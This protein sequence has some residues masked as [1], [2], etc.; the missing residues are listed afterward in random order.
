MVKRNAK[1]LATLRTFLQAIDGAPAERQRYVASP[2]DFTRHRSLT[3]LCMVGLLA[4]LL[5]RSLS[6]ELREFFSEALARPHGV[7]KSAFCQQRTK[8]KPAL[9]ADLNALLGVA[10]CE[11]YGEHVRRW[12]GYRLC[13]VDGTRLYLPDTPAVRARYG[14]QDNQHGGV[15]MAQVVTL[16]DV[17]NELTCW[18][19]I[20]PVRTSE[21]AIVADHVQD[22][23][24]D[25]ITLF[26]RGYASA[27]FC[28]QLRQANRPFVMRAKLTFNAQVRAFVASPKKDTI[29]YFTVS[30]A[31]AAK[32]GH[33]VPAGAAVKVRMVKVWLPHGQ[34]EV[35]LT[36]LYDRKRFTRA[37]LKFLYGQRWGAET[38]YGRQKNELQLE[39]FSGLR[40]LC[41][42]QDFF[43]TLL[44]DNLQ[45][46]VERQCEPKLEAVGRRRKHRYKINRNVAMAALKHH[47]VRLL[48]ADNPLQELLYLQHLFEQNLEPVRPHRTYKRVKK[49]HRL[50]GKFYTVT[51]SKRGI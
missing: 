17:P 25:G 45:A 40:P 3:L 2:T 27:A 48:L 5:K 8:L 44:V 6:V 47:V 11:S 43:A 20:R 13:A 30:P 49:V 41:I 18:G 38:A 12:R 23:P 50:H 31:A 14:T 16:R 36:N 4:N 10:F 22:L 34:L 29:A 15:P 9:F 19:D 35:L 21:L 46:L 32:H 1:I 42:E 24:A 26:D 33:H 37:D 7:S 39:Q 28:C 51:N